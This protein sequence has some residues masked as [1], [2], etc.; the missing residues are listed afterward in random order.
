MARYDIKAFL[1]ATKYIKYVLT[2]FLVIFIFYAVFMQDEGLVVAVETDSDLSITTSPSSGFI[3][4]PNMAPGQQAAAPLTV[5][6]EGNL[7]FSYDIEVV[8]E[9]GSEMY[10]SVL[11]LV[12][13]DSAQ[14]VLYNGKLKDL[15]D[16]VL[17]VLGAGGTDVFD[18]QVG[19]PAEC[20]NE[21]Q[22][23]STGVTFVLN[24]V[25]HPPYIEG[26]GVVWDPPLEKPDVHVRK[27]MIMPIR[28][29]LVQNGTFEIIK[30]GVD[31][32]ITG[33][34]DAGQPVE[35]IFSVVDDTLEW[36]EHGLH[37]PHYRLMFD[38]EKYPVKLDTYYTAAVKYGDQKLEPQTKFISGH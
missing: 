22:G 30:R 35:Y 14:N 24:A 11:D 28:F 8:M 7:D 26:G 37:K 15:N 21:Y 19:F 32:V 5:K 4:A 25:E 29:H 9:N 1:K 17:G 23:L 12:I 27:G 13:K 20:G 2:V 33:V 36:E 31:L 3:S 34:N 10:Y 18:F 16:L 6:N 38:A